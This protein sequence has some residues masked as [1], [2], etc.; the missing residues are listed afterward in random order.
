MKKLNTLLLFISLSSI[1]YSQFDDDTVIIESLKVPKN[2]WTVYYADSIPRLLNGKLYTGVDT[3]HFI[4]GDEKLLALET[5]KDGLKVEIKT[6]FDNGN[7][8]RYFQYKNGKREGISKGWYKSGKIMFDSKMKDGKDVGTRITFYENGNPEYV[9]DESSGISM[10]FYE[11]GKMQSL[12]KHFNDSVRCGNT[13]GFEETEWNEDGQLES[14][15][16]SN[17]GKQSYTTYYNDTTLFTDE[18][19]IDMSLYH[20]GKY[21]KWYR[22]GTVTIAGQYLDGN[23]RNESNIKTGIWKYFDKKGKLV[24]EEYYENNTLK[25]VKD[26]APKNHSNEIPAKR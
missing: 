12:A 26:Y 15:Q 8:E 22:D 24:K 16:I 10:G 21:T 4:S 6:F 13:L 25:K 2:Y 7:P 23:T 1:C 5:F 14:K 20:V 18:T 3:N 11:N 9:A 17:C 19:I